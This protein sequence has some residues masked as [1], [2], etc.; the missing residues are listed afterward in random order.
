MGQDGSRRKN[1]ANITISL[2]VSC[3]VPHL[4]PCLEHKSQALK[5][6]DSDKQY[7]FLMFLI[8]AFARHGPIRQTCV[9]V[10]RG[11]DKSV[12]AREVLGLL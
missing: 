7:M 1:D 9:S 8:I 5:L 2:A 4:C 11:S 6:P 10:S 3:V 12:T